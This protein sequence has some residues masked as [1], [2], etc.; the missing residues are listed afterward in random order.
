MTINEISVIVI[1]LISFLV[2]ASGIQTLINKSKHESIIKYLNTVECLKFGS[3]NCYYSA[4]GLKKDY[5][6]YPCNLE[7]YLTHN[8]VFF[9]GKMN[10]PYIFKTYEIPFSLSKNP[11]ETKNKVSIKRVFRPTEVFLNPNN[12]NVD[13][14]DNLTI[15]T[16]ISFQVSLNHPD[17]W[18][19]LKVVG[20]WI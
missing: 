16:K 18:E 14:I 1:F 17:N 11:L 12:F 13:F 15:Q 8:E 5:P 3:K 9:L 20:Q 10:F 19:K 4:F 7:I 6:S 2:I